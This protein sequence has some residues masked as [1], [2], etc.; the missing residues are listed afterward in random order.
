MKTGG[1]FIHQ[2]DS[3]LHTTSPVEAVFARRKRIGEKP[4]HKPAEKLNAWLNLLER[5][6]SG[7]G[8]SEARQ[9]AQPQVL[10]RIKALYHRPTSE[11]G[12]L[13]GTSD[14]AING[15]LHHQAEIAHQ[16]GH[17]EIEDIMARVNN[18]VR[19]EARSSIVEDQT[20]SLDRWVDYLTSE[21]ASYPAWFKYYVFRNIAKLA[22][23][24]KDKDNG[25]DKTT[26][27]PKPKG[28]FPSRSADTTAPFP[29]I[30]REAL[31]YMEDS[32][33]KHYGLK[34]TDPNN[35]A[36]QIDEKTL[37]VLKNDSS[38]ASL[39][40]R[41]IEYAAPKHNENLNVSDGRWVKFDQTT[42]RAKSDELAHSLHGYGTGWCTAGEG[43]A[44]SQ[45]S[46][47][48]FYV[49]FTKS[50]DGQYSVPRVAIRMQNN[51][52]RQEIAEVRGIEAEQ[53]LEGELT[54]ITEAKMREVDP[55]GA[56]SYTNKA[57]DMRH[58]TEIEKF[59]KDNPNTGL[60][61]DNLIFLYELE[62]PIE[63]FGYESDPRVLQLQ[64][65]AA[66]TRNYIA[67]KRLN[68]PNKVLNFIHIEQ[69]L[70]AASKHPEIGFTDEDLMLVYE[71]RG[72]VE[73]LDPDHLELARSIDYWH[74]GRD[75]E[76]IKQLIPE[77]IRQQT[78]TSY[79]AVQEV[80]HILGLEPISQEQFNRAFDTKWAEWESNG[81]LAWVAD[82]FD[83]YGE[84]YTLV[85]TPNTLKNNQQILDLVDAFEILQGRVS[86]YK[87]IHHYAYEKGDFEALTGTSESGQAIHFS[88]IPDKFTHELGYAAVDT[89][90]QALTK[91]QAV[92]SNV[93]IPSVLES[94]SYWFAL[95]AGNS[96]Y[97]DKITEKTTIRHI[98]SKLWYLD[99]IRVPVLGLRDSSSAILQSE[100]LDS[101]S[102]ARI[103]LG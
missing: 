23:Y 11:G 80:L 19:A 77:V 60:S 73:S 46:G 69:L 28:G 95:R 81:T 17:G 27:E 34:A 22:S 86:Y 40:K 38:F 97:G 63:G 56:E 82:R 65:L 84:R 2:K 44:H 7:K 48:D 67:L 1:E 30:N 83:R 12:Y 21:D 15:Y 31:A 92:Q 6:H 20:R 93:Q 55:H 94:V 57:A 61:D 96:L 90:K 64:R 74:E 78:E 72:A 9:A 26:G 35:P 58:L 103:S 62:S 75:R 100:S 13:T 89:Q 85:A 29:D 33:A 91:L 101:R 53:N 79:K 37:H 70:E 71:M 76:R 66:T 98:V 3:K 4:S 47:G 102:Y 99:V 24:D 36:D 49:Y 8:G 51:G 42:D 52:G 14:K 5:T 59:L 16:Q 50:E 41:A 25:I 39:Y 18:Q 45:L 88:L 43:M 87:N 54:G 32:L 68:A 10:E